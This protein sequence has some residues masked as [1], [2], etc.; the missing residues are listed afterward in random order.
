MMTI[1][2]A[3]RVTRDFLLTGLTLRLFSNYFPTNHLNQVYL[4]RGN[5]VVSGG[6]HTVIL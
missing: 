3:M 5:L 4:L 2:I 1:W 6:I